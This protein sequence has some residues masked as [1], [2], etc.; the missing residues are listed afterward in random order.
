MNALKSND[1]S[2]CG[3]MPNGAARVGAP[4]PAGRIRP[5]P[6]GFSM[7]AGIPEQAATTA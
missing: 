6:R 1:F 4:Y 7:R 2:A 5:L 3:G